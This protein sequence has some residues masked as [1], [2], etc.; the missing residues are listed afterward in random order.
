MLLLLL[1]WKKYPQENLE[2]NEFKCNFPFAK[3][4]KEFLSKEFHETNVFKVVQKPEDC[5]KYEIFSLI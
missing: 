4:K 1:N 3:L 2:C 5:S